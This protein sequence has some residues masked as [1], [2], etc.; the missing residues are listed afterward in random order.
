M[1]KRIISNHGY[2]LISLLLLVAA[3]AIDEA[4]FSDQKRRVKSKEVITA[5]LEREIQNLDDKINEVADK[6][7]VDLNRLFNRLG[8]NESLPH[9]I[10]VDGKLAYWSTSRFIP[11]YALVDGSYLYRFVNI[12][13]GQY[14][15]RRKVFNSSSNQLIEIFGFLP[16]S[17]NIPI[18][19]AF[20]ENGINT[21]VF[22]KTNFVLV[23]VRN[24]A[25]DQNIVSREGIFLFSFEGP[26][27]IK[28]H[29]PSYEAFIFVLYLLVI[30]LFIVALF[31]YGNRLR[32]DDKPLLAIILLTFGLLLVRL[33]LLR[34]EYPRSIFDIGMFDPAFY[35]SAWWQPSLGDLLLNE[36]LILVVVIYALRT[37]GKIR[38]GLRTP[39][40]ALV[41]GLYL[42]SFGGLVYHILQLQSILDNSQWTLDIARDISLDLMKMAS[43]LAFFINGV[44]YF[45]IAQYALA[46][47]ER[48]RNAGVVYLFLGVLLLLGVVVLISYPSLW[49]MALVVHNFYLMVIFRMKLSS[50]VNKASYKTFL[51]FFIS[52]FVLAFVHTYI[53]V[54]HIRHT[55][56]QDKGTLATELLSEN[57]L[58]AEF[59]LREAK[60]SIEKDILI[61]AN[62]SNQ[63]FPKDLLREKVRQS[64]LGEYFDK[65]DIEVLLFNGNGRPINNPSS[66]KYQDLL[67]VYGSEQYSTGFDALFFVKQEFPTAFTQYY[68]FNEIKRYQVVVGYVVLKLDR[69]QRLGNSILPRLLVENRE[70]VMEAPQFDYALYRDGRLTTAQGGF[71]Y[72]RDFSFN[73]EEL[74]VLQAEGLS[75]NGYYHIAVPGKAPNEYYII[76]SESYPRRFVITNFSVFFLFLVG[77]IILFFLISAIFY[78]TQRKGVSISAKIQLLLNFAFFLP[79]IIVSIVVLRLVN[80][81][82]QR[83]IETEYL[84]RAE[85]AGNNLISPLQE[86]LTGQNENARSLEN[87]VTEISQY[88]QVDINLFN[89]NGRLIASNQNLIF[90][91]QI[92]APFTN[93]GAMASLVENGN[94]KQLSDEFLGNLTYQSTYYGIRSSDDNRLLGVLSMP[95]FESEGQLKRQQTEILSN[96]L[97]AFTFIFIIFVVLSFFAS[98]MLTYPFT[99]LTQKIKATT[100]SK[101]NEPLVWSADDEI[102]LMVKEYNRM[103][104]NLEK[105]KKALALS[106]KESAWREMAQ[107][108][109]HEIKNP[110]TPMKLKLQH[111]QRV[112][113][114]GKT[115]L[116]DDYKKPIESLLHQVDTL[117]DIATS[118]S[119]FAKMPIPLSEKLDL[120][121]TLKR[122][123][124]LFNQDEIDMSSNI[125]RDPVWIEGDQKLLGRIFNNLILNAQQAVDEGVSPKLEVELELTSVR[126]RILITDNGS[127][128]PDDIKEKI[129]IPKFSTKEKGS[130]IGL[131]IAKRGVEHAG[132]SIW[133]ESEPGKGTTFYLEFPLMD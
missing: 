94:T 82:V 42:I 31:K 73:S 6:A 96:I 97:N 133:F 9:F 16:L 30:A 83:N 43:Y 103:L 54:G 128:I 129:F 66:I 85:S 15:V 111:L 68:L 28:V 88:S 107:Q 8:E 109:A 70:S 64:Y 57:D 99:F 47:F 18:D 131:A 84:E 127:G 130:G 23:D 71:N 91:N 108:V 77:L 67:A 81:T 33:V 13:S 25:K 87:R 12:K 92:L 58:T 40:L 123:I 56:I 51:Y 35:A 1:L 86:F 3:L 29:Y 119:S 121:D 63:F 52:A 118:F 2:L 95:F 22:E 59:L 34:Y 102:G 36:I 104:I 80:N 115:E 32:N 20:Q 11:S 10:Y 26:D 110:L 72:D 60:T 14:L 116:G 90:E 49:L 21:R 132:G 112:L 98:R 17:A 4:I 37:L 5:N 62:I 76:S 50:Q 113:T 38:L 79:L 46:A 122:A 126:A 19:P 101:Y 48:F 55:D 120:A 89:T 93:P 27:K 105:S 75:K 44:V 39:S 78:N 117:S 74:E 7:I 124:R 53:L 125:P 41:I 65:Y 24:A 45:L 69:Q 114:S 61:Q 100:F 106:E